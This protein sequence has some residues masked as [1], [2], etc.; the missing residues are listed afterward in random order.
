M[1]ILKIIQ[2]RIS[3][4]AYTQII[5]Y[6]LCFLVLCSLLLGAVG[7]L[8]Y[9]PVDQVNS[10]SVL[11]A[12]YLLTNFLF[13][14]LLKKH[15]INDIQI[16]TILILFYIFTPVISNSEMLMLFIAGLIAMTMQFL[17]AFPIIAVAMPPILATLILISTG[18]TSNFL[19]WSGSEILLPIA[20]ILSIIVVFKILGNKNTIDIKNKVI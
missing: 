16:I 11:V 10:L 6:G 4:F 19:W 17:F 18:T 5:L 1:K 3:Y 7:I 9:R 20:G 12:A 15:T 13:V 14:T 8:P 2:N